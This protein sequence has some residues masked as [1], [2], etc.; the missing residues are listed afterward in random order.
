MQP[1]LRDRPVALDSRRRDTKCSCGFIDLAILDWYSRYVLAWDLSVT[2]D[3]QFCLAALTR[4][5][6]FLFRAG[7]IKDA[8]ITP[9]DVAIDRPSV[10]PVVAFHLVTHGPESET[11]IPAV[12]SAKRA[13]ALT[14]TLPQARPKPP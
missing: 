2:V 10:L 11:S 7:S 6:K 13:D 12:G 9:T 4:S 1:R 5:V 3:G 8:L 14:Q